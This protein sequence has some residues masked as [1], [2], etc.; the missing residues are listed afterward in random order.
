MTYINNAALIKRQ[1][2]VRLA[3]MMFD[4]TLGTQVDY[5]PLQQAP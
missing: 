5:I 2:M 1:L 3:R 4:G